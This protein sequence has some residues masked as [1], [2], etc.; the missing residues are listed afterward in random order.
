MCRSSYFT[1]DYRRYFNSNSSVS[2]QVTG[3]NRG[4]TWQNKIF[5]CDVHSRRFRLELDLLKHFLGRL[6]T[7]ET[8]ILIIITNSYWT[9]SH[10][11]SPYCIANHSYCLCIT[12]SY[13]NADIVSL[14]TVYNPQHYNTS[15]CLQSYR[16]SVFIY[17]HWYGNAS[18]CSWVNSYVI[19]WL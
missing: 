18:S 19:L 10:D 13:L 9:A 7:C 2:T 8:S 5:S 4:R 3:R 14:V 12:R 16:F 17:I 11:L 6:L 15:H 1:K